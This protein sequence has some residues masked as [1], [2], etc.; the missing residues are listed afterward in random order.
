MI[1]KKP[2]RPYKF[3]PLIRIGNAFDGG[4]V[5]PEKAVLESKFL[6]SLGINDD[7]S[8][9]LHFCHMN[10]AVICFGVDYTVTSEFLKRRRMQAVV[11]S[12]I[13]LLINKTK[14]TI[15]STKAKNI[16]KFERFFSG[17]NKFYPL[18]VSDVSAPGKITISE[19]LGQFPNVKSHDVF[20][21]M[22]IEGDEY[23]VTDEIV[24]N[25]DKIGY[26]ACEYHFVSSDASTFNETIRKMSEAFYLAH[27][28]GNNHGKYSESQQFPDTL[29]LTWVNKAKLQE[30]PAKSDLS[31]PLEN[32]DAPCNFKAPD[33]KIILDR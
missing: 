2:L 18:Q 29:E 20:L 25:A 16:A 8:F 7:I 14:H 26:V 12:W 32:L 33:Y 17:K 10:P 22:D 21:K 24:K 31:Y 30:K 3:E 9:D 11:K 1:D 6:L 23:I 4:Y 15:Y 13:N 27:I 5:L 19:L 28:H